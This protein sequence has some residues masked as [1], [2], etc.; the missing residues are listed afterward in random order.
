MEDDV[1]A[2][3]PRALARLADKLRSSGN[4]GVAQKI[5]SASNG[6]SSTVEL[7]LVE[8]AH[9]VAAICAIGME[10]GIEPAL[11]RLQRTLRAK[12]QREAQ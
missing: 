12:I 11:D 5:A 6:D 7:D 8:D 2:I 3:S 1:V 9:V 10:D 4:S